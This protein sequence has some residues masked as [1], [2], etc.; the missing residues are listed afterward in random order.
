VRVQVETTVRQLTV[1]IAARNE[2][3]TI[4]EKIINTLALTPPPGVDVQ[5]LVASDAS[6]DGTDEIVCEF[7]PAHVLLVRS[8]ERRGKEVAQRLA[9]ERARGEVVVF[10]D[11]KVRLEADALVRLVRYF[12]EPSIGAVSSYDRIEGSGASVEGLYVR[13]EMWVRRLETRFSTVVGL[14]GSTFAV[15]RALCEGM[16]TDVPSDFALLIRT[17][18]CGYRG[19]L[20]EDVPCWYRAVANEEAEF[21]RKVRTVLR[22]ITALATCAPELRP[23]EFHRLR[24]EYGQR[25]GAGGVS[26]WSFLWQLCSH[27]GVRW[28]IP[29]LLV[30]TLLGAALLAHT[31]VFFLLLADAML[32]FFLCALLGYLYPHL[33]RYRVIKIPLYFT[34]SN[35]AI[36]RAWHRYLLGDRSISWTPTAREGV[37]D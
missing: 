32:V 9:I 20:A 2:A 27:K 6:D 4:R 1:V 26:Y 37:R 21:E 34:L 8:P 29:L 23:G 36:A 13:Y 16:R 14:S 22:G 25:D 33:R 5:I 11:A 31:G 24:R 18:V 28:L 17:V 15:R 30:V 3:A 12:S 19:V 10:T 7:E 35:L